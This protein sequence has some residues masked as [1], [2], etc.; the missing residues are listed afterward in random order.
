MH[1]VGIVK[2]QKG[3]QYYKVKNSWGSNSKRVGND[4]FIY[5]SIPYF[6]LKAISILVHKNSLPNKIR[7]ANGLI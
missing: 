1:I 3:N 6:K 7:N 2:D 5:M 4:G